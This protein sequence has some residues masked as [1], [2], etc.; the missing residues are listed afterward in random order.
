MEIAS[1]RSALS[2]HYHEELPCSFHRGSEKLQLRYI[3]IYICGII[4]PEDS[5]GRD[6]SCGL[7]TVNTV[8]KFEH[9]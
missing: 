4:F 2:P 8:V 5:K 6:V 7:D 9:L 3:Y 1:G